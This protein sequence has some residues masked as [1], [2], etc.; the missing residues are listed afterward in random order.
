MRRTFDALDVS[1]VTLNRP[2]SDVERTCVPPHSSREYEPS[3]ISTI[4]PPPP[5][6]SPN[7]AIAPL[8]R[9]SSSVVCW[10]RTGSLARIHSLT[11]PSPSP[12]SSGVSA[13]LG[14]GRGAGGEGEA[15][16]VGADIRAGLTHVRPQPLAQRG[17][18]QM[19]GGVV[20]LGRGPGPAVDA[21]PDARA[22]VQRS[23]LELHDHRLVVA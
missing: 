10:G 21:R 18:Q 2:I 3:P 13:A 7:S 5:Y 11:R 19:R 8:A 16:L 22:L 14:G 6:F 9:A 12:R 20:G 23:L 1:V 17:M 4:P 15:Q